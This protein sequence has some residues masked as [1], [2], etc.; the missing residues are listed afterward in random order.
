MCVAITEAGNGQY[1]TMGKPAQET[2]MQIPEETNNGEYDTF[3]MLW[4]DDKEP[5]IRDG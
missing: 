5:W 2:S 4:S 3:H 1:G